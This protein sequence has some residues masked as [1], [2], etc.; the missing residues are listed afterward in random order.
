MAFWNNTDIE[1]KQKSK[2]IVSFGADFYLPNVKSVSKPSL[3]VAIKEFKLINHVFN[4]P[5]TVKWNPITITFIDMNGGGN[6]FDTSALL[7]QMLNN[8][9]YATPAVASHQLATGAGKFVSITTPDKS[10]T[11]ANAFG[12][13]LTGKASTSKASPISQN[14]KISQL[15]PDGKVNETWT[16]VNPMIKSIKYGDLSYDSDEPVEYVL[17]VIYDF[18]TYN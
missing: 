14:V 9:G 6:A 4:Y 13:G 16:L 10:S 2:F 1:I 12:E 3:E 15:T 18:A 17:E 11:I 8:T 5:G 7:T